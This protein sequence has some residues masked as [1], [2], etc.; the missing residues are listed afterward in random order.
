MMHCMNV[1]SSERMM[2]HKSLKNP[3]RSVVDQ[4]FQKE[5]RVQQIGGARDLHL[6][7]IIVL[8]MQ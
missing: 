3:D 1:G 7:D 6:W 5:K 8:C 4:N 2:A